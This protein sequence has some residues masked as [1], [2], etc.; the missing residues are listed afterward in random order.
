MLATPFP[1]KTSRMIFRIMMSTKQKIPKLC[2][3]RIVCQTGFLG[4]L[5]TQTRISVKAKIKSKTISTMV[6]ARI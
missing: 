5:V 2:M 3:G 1:T 6:D 4:S